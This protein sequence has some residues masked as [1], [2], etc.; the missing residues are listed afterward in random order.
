MTA[1]LDPA[2]YKTHKTSRGY[3][4]SYYY[5]ASKESKP[6]LVFLHGF[7]STSNDWRYQ[8]AHFKAKGYGLIVPDMLGYGGTDKPLEVGVYVGSGLTRDVVDLMD[9]EGVQSAVCVAHDWYVAIFLFI[10][11]PRS[12]SSPNSSGVIIKQGLSCRCS[13]RKLVPYPLLCFRFF[14]S[15]IYTA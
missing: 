10:F 3:T 11:N 9:G 8:V 5:S 4:Y 14:R 6:T 7:P 1:N 2:S 15:G 13:T 12:R